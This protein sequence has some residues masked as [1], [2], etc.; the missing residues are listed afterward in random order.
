[1]R[2][3]LLLLPIA[4]L[5][6]AN[7]SSEEPAAPSE[8]V[9]PPTR[10]VSFETTE[11]TW[12]GVDLHPDGD[13]F[14]FDLLGD[15]YVL[16]VDGGA[17]TRLTS[18]P[19]WDGDARWS[20]D[21]S[22]LVFSSDRGG[23]RNLWLMDADGGRPR[24]LTDDAATRYSEPAWTPDGEYVIARRRFT[25][26]SSIGLQE[27]WMTHRL[28]GA[29]VQ[30]TKKEGLGGATEPALSP[31]GRFIYFSGRGGRYSYNRDPNRGI[32]QIRR[33]DRTTGQQRPITGQA[34]GAV[35]PTPSPD[36]TRL[37]VV[38]RVRA[39]TTLEMLDLA[40]GQ[41]TRI[42]DWLDPDEQEGFA[43]NGLYPR[44][45]WFDDNEHLLVFA[46]GGFW[47]VHA[48]TGERTR[49]PFT[50]QVDLDVTEAV[51]Q[52]R[53][54]VADEVQARLVR[55]PVV[56]PDGDTLVFGALGRLWTMA[57]P[58]GAPQPL[59][60]DA[61]AREFG[62]AWSPDGKWIAY[63]GWSDER[64][65]SVRLA[66]A[67]GGRSRVVGEV[68]PKYSNPS[69]SPDGRELVMLRGSGQHKRGGELAW[70]LWSDII[71]M[72]AATGATEVVA[73]AAGFKRG[74]RPRFSADGRRILLPEDK[75]GGDHQASNGVVVSMNRDGSDRRELLQIGHALDA[76]TS[77]DGRWVGFVEKH[78]AWVALIPEAGQGPHVI[79]M[80]GGGVP[81]W[82]LSE[83]AG[84]WVDFS[85]DSGSVTWN[86]GPDVHR[87]ELA[88]LVAWE[89]QRQEEA[90][91]EAEEA[92]ASEGE[93]AEGDDDDSAV[94]EDEEPE[95]PPSD[96]IRID[97]RVPRAVP[98]G[99][100]AITGA[101][102]V[103]MSGDAVIDGG[104]VVVDRDPLVARRAARGVGPAAGWGPGGADGEVPVPGDAHVVDAAGA[105]LIPGLIDVHGHAHF[106]AVDVMPEQ[107][108][109]YH[110]N[111]AYGVT[112]LHDPSAFS[113]QVF[114]F[115]EM[116][117][118]GFLVGPRIFSTGMVLY[119]AGG[120]YR[121]DVRRGRPAPRSADEGAGGDLHQE[122]PA[123]PPG[124]APLARRGLPRR[125]AARRARGRRRHLGQPDHGGGRPQ[126]HRARHPDGAA[127]R[128]RPAAARGD[129]HL[130]LA[131]AAGRLWRPVGRVR[132]LRPQPGL[133]GRAARH[134]HPA[135]R[136]RRQGAS[137]HRQRHRRG[138]VAPS[139][140]GA[141]RRRPG[142]RGRA[143]DGRRP[144]PDAGV[145][146]ALGDVGAGVRGRDD[147]PR[148]AARRHHRGGAVPRHGG[149]PR[150]GGG[151][152]ARRPGARRRRPAGRHH[153]QRQ[154]APRDQGRGALR[155]RHHGPPVARPGAPAA[156]RVG[157][158]PG[159]RRVAVYARP[160]ALAAAVGAAFA[161]IIASSS[162]AT[163]FVCSC[164]PSTILPR[165]SSEP[166]SAASWLTR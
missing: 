56:S 125:G 151:R 146:H 62:A 32:W 35:R 119:G 76:V 74:A 106:S 87:L 61:Q 102:I 77:P 97:L 4:L 95:L 137:P 13:R 84:D 22:T 70:E 55:W 75:H 5:P 83:V 65:G 152:Q 8:E 91:L 94:E 165:S 17:A 147:A 154:R 153:R 25:D 86:N 24:A 79:A 134:L 118:A 121:S 101:R 26:T 139:Q 133:G 115:G 3:L 9:E 142:P 105:T 12:M 29:G 58:D 40:T 64:G 166:A 68:G 163:A 98:A 123:A 128:R 41:L 150:L 44:M 138:G 21:G 34:G 99:R 81:A 57:L 10:E 2:R 15:L 144:R 73:A 130:L 140:G 80:E 69:F 127:V 155:R 46:E 156:V 116:V 6:L 92:E 114:T 112:T 164:R 159:G 158:R 53:S 131:D 96:V 78:H 37:A 149:A 51:R 120:A 145:G 141:V 1:M 157:A 11:G 136:A 54:P 126:R 111:L 108:W 38:R 50:A 27:L 72:D 90:R 71:V 135:P 148:G 88:S 67:R 48:D 16:P 49:I 109:R 42:G 14:V 122:L 89:E 143:R 117:E 45:D 103:T 18:G 7:V 82:Q 104:T 30:L 43:V 162:S 52:P 63:V 93:E 85:W 28:G 132:V 66:P 107:D 161:S 31:D 39:Q 160:R 60:K 19:E 113:D 20:P 23:N 100:L 59:T 36:G 124:A 129:R 110:A 47:K 33:Y